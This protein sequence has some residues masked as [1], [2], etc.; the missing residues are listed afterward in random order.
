L[1]KYHAALSGWFSGKSD[2]ESVDALWKAM[3]L[4]EMTVLSP[5]G[6]GELNAPAVRDLL[7][8]ARGAYGSS[9]YTEPRDIN[10]SGEGVE[11]AG[12]TISC[13]FTEWQHYPGQA[14]PRRIATKAKC[15]SR[16]APE[17]GVVWLR[18]VEQLI[19]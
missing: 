6:G 7:A 11:T 15:A 4:G 16:E 9:F 10:C 8:A 13:T 17:K 18:F 14:R 2:L 12:I 1:V 5:P 19:P 3:D